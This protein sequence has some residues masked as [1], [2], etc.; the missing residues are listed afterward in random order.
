MDYRILSILTLLCWGAWGFLCKM[1]SKE[2]PAAVLVLW[3]NVGGFVPMLLYVLNQ[4]SFRWMPS[5]EIALLAGF[6]GSAATIM[7]YLALGRGPASVV[8]PMTGMYIIVPALLGFIFLQEPLGIRHIAGLLC[9][10]AAIWLL[11]S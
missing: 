3:S 7:F 8:V 11:A 4:R 1:V 6:I 10:G 2:L 5:S 9:A